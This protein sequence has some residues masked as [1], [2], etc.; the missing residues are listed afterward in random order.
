MTAFPKFDKGS[1][2][3][4]ELLDILEQMG[5][6]KPLLT[7]LTIPNVETPSEIRR[8]LRR[9]FDCKARD[10][11]LLWAMRTH[12]QEL[13]DFLGVDKT[14]INPDDPALKIP[15]TNHVRVTNAWNFLKKISGARLE[16][17]SVDHIV[18]LSFGGNNS[19]TNMC[20]LP[21]RINELK[22]MFEKAQRVYTPDKPQI[23]TLV[24]RKTTSGD[25]QR[26]IRA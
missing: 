21:V 20:L 18:P 16:G 23:V 19:A 15:N 1:S 10:G 12:K 4:V 14:L 22:F 6:Y 25:Y 26:F 13:A 2:L 7:P 11:F 9:D 3:K 8:K 24:P 17:Y 5:P